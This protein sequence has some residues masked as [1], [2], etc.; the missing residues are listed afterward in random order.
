VW[1]W[2]GQIVRTVLEDIVGAPDRDKARRAAEA[3]SKMVKLDLAVLQR[4]F[5][6]TAPLRTGAHLEWRG[7]GSA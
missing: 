6:V 7:T 4:A 2:S 5:D 1:A 3:M